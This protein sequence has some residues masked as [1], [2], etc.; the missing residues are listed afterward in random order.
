MKQTTPLQIICFG[1]VALIV[2]L[3]VVF[4]LSLPPMPKY[5]SIPIL[6]IGFA[7]AIFTFCLGLMLTGVDVFDWLEI[8]FANKF[9]NN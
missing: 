2:A 9:G 1:A 8:Y 5:L 6:I 7:S 3:A 4:L